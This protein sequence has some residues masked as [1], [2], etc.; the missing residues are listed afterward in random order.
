M[1]KQSESFTLPEQT[2]T[3]SSK[4]F[5]Q[6]KQ[7]KNIIIEGNVETIGDLSFSKIEN[8]FSIIFKGDKQS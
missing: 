7:I 4:A 6:N 5:Y 1:N 8:E 3:I 2:T